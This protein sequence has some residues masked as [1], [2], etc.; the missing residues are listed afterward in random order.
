VC[1]ASRQ[2]SLTPIRIAIAEEALNLR[3]AT[4]AEIAA[5]F[6]REPQSLSEL[7]SRYRHR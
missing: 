1:S 6:K 2:R 5:L 7:L 3:I 4:L